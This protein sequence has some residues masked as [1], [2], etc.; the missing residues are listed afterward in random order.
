MT[1][2]NPWRDKSAGKVSYNNKNI[3]DFFILWTLAP[4]LMKQIELN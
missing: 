2:I 3:L 1:D 4:F